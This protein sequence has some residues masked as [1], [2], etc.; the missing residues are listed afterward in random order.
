[1][2]FIGSLPIWNIFESYNDI[3]HIIKNSHDILIRR[4]KKMAAMQNLIL[5]LVLERVSVAEDH[6]NCDD[7]IISSRNNLLN[8]KPGLSMKA[9][10]REIGITTSCKTVLPSTTRRQPGSGS[11]KTSPTTGTRISTPSQIPWGKKEYLITSIMD[12]FTKIPR[13]NVMN[14]CAFLWS[15]LEEIFMCMS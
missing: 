8:D 15:H 12:V 13:E 7:D 5:G 1:M 4:I 10:A 3:L 14:A 6:V 11:L 9:I 2:D